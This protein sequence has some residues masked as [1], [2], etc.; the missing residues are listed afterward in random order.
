VGYE[1]D[2]DVEISPADREL[3]NEILCRASSTIVP[4]RELAELCRQRGASL[5][6]L[7]KVVKYLVDQGLIVELRCRLFTTKEYFGGRSAEELVAEIKEK[8]S[9]TGIKKCGRPVSEKPSNLVYISVSK[10]RGMRVS[11]PHLYLSDRGRL[12]G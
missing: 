12:Q 9:R 11:I 1:A 3:A 5:Q 6:R 7:R 4:W 10:K 8:L 2:V